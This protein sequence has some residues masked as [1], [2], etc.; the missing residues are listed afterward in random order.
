MVRNGLAPVMLG[1]M[2]GIA[3]ALLSGRAVAGMLFGVTPHD[4]LSLA[5]VVV[6]L[7]RPPSW[8]ATCPR[9]VR[10]GGPDHRAQG[11]VTGRGENT[12]W[13][14]V[15]FRQGFAVQGL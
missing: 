15:I 7:D 2:A 9:V 6:A 8:R 10:E 14:Q 12:R 4:P 5:I 13:R 3:G 11:G 1:L